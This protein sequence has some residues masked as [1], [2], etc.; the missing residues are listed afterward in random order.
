MVATQIEDRH[1]VYR[2]LT[3]SAWKSKCYRKRRG[4]RSWTAAPAKS[5]EHKR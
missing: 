4:K 2:A 1:K 5:Q 3:V